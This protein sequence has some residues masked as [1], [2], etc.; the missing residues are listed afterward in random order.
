M[1]KLHFP[2][3]AR[4]PR[5]MEPATVSI[6][7]PKGT[8][9][10]SANCRIIDENGQ[11]FPGQFRPTAL[12]PDGSVKWLLVHLQADLPG[13]SS[14]DYYLDIA[15]DNASSVT[16]SCEGL[17]TA[18]PTL[19]DNG[20]LRIALPVSAGP[21]F[22]SID[23]PHGCFTKE[24]ISPFTITDKSG[25]I[26][27]AGTGEKGW[28]VIESGPVRAML[29]TRGRHLGE[30][31]TYF[32]YIITMY[33]YVGKPWVDLDY[34]VINTEDGEP[35]V[36][37]KACEGL[38]V[39][40]IK[41][42]SLKICPAAAG[43]VA[44]YTAHSNY[45]TLYQD[46]DGELLIDGKYLQFT[47]SEQSPE[48]LYGTFYADWH[49]EKRGVAAT[50]YQAQQ[51]F[52]KRVAVSKDALTV[53]L[54]PEET[55]EVEF[56]E[57]VSKTHRIQL[58]F[59]APDADRHMDITFRTLQYQLPDKPIISPDV[60]EAS[61]LFEDIFN[62]K[63]DRRMELYIEQLFNNRAKT[64][65]I[66]HWG[67]NPDSGYTLAGRGMGEY[68]WINGEYDPGRAF[69]LYYI[70]H[71]SRSAYGAMK[72]AT[73]HIL[74]VDICHYGSNPT[75][76]R[77]HLPHAA[78]HATSICTP[79]HEWVE[80]LIDYYHET[81][82][83]EVLEIALGVGH[84]IVYM[85]EHKIFCQS[86]DNYAAARE[87]GWALFSMT[88]L[89]QETYDEYWLKHCDT[90]ANY[91]FDWEKKFGAFLAPYT[92]HTLAR[93]PFMIAVAINALKCLYNI[94]PTEELKGL[95]IRS[96]ED[97]A[98]NCISEYTGLFFYKELP[99]LNKSTVIILPLASMTYAY[100]LS[101]DVKFLKYGLTTLE[102]LLSNIPSPKSGKKLSYQC[103]LYAAGSASNKPF[104]AGA[105]SLLLYYKALMD[106][107]L[108]PCR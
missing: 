79:S 52:P 42:M 63:L 97:L 43:K 20:V 55:G 37:E 56:I 84:N 86:E 81:G 75:R 1:I 72:C 32:D 106:N 14:A 57:G 100:Q 11:L 6:P 29:R 96:A 31:R 27:T 102:T 16:D 24:E 21:L 99:S 61:G 82:D 93:V 58:L 5:A 83:P 22:E 66:L 94:R 10:T 38:T 78:R 45:R 2:K 48:V 36:L 19:V 89:Y 71:G 44:T 62:T 107:D 26:Y 65:G 41:S 105:Q 54:I 28:E 68:V 49:D 3:L 39:S 64:F 50:I 60:Y 35:L 67:D 77:G 30:N 46:G 23:T 7:F 17:L 69:F 92:D 90:I 53:N 95:I 80:G 85:L 15:S 88:A 13:N 34:R 33:I 101:K 104:A 103:M 91:F 9:S 70:T 25:N 73:E 18:S 12:W 51:N 98:L 74:D 87:A 4:Y 59:H 76:Y 8:L 47:D 108:F 40:H